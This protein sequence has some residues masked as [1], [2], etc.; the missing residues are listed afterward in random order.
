ME[1]GAIFCGSAL[2]CDLVI[3]VLPIG[4]CSTAHLKYHEIQCR[5]ALPFLWE[6][7]QNHPETFLTSFVHYL[8]ITLSCVG[9][10]FLMPC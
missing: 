1:I 6:H 4:S 10:E 8:A 9:R 5:A 3:E 7:L 2:Q